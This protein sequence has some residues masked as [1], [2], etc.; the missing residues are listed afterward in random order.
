MNGVV[1]AIDFLTERKQEILEISIVSAIEVMIGCRNKDELK[2]L[3]RLFAECNIIPISSSISQRAYYLAESYT[4]SHGLLLGDA[5][6]DATV[7]ELE[8]TLYTKNI[9]HF[10]MIPSLKLSRP[11]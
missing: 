8:D 6:I 4:L 11:Y 10:R 9:R 7:L 1:E 3:Q 2:E 5:L